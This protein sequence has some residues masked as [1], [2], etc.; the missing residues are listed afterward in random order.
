MRGPVHTP[1][2]DYV[3]DCRGKPPELNDDYEELV[4]PVNCCLLG[5]SDKRE[6]NA[7]W[8]KAIAT[9]DGWTFVIPNT[10]ETTSYGYLFNEDITTRDEAKQNFLE[11]FGV[12]SDDFLPFKKYVAKKA[13]DGRVIK[14]GNKLFFLEPLEGAALATY[15]N[16]AIKAYRWIVLN[17]R[18]WNPENINQSLRNWV[19]ESEKFV[20]WHYSTG[21]KFNTKFWDYATE[22]A[23][24]V[25]CKKFDFMLEETVNTDLFY[26]RSPQGRQ[27]TYGAWSRESLKN[28][29]DNAIV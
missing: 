11:M 2:P 4:N 10:T 6:A 22:L 9:R 29:Y 26:L 14:N 1:V 27:N 3:F 25:E 20:L 23:K 5:Q 21:S 8:T 12:E 17:D 13:F 15:L 24:T 18:E 16:L 19:K 28:W 7:N